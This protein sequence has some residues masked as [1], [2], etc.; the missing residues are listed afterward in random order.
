MGYTYNGHPTACAVAMANLDIIE[1]E[2]LLAKAKD[3]GDYLLRRL[4][5]LTEL[6]VVGE[7]RGV[8]MMLAIELVTDEKSRAPLLPT[9]PVE[10]VARH[11]TGVI[12]RNCGHSVVLS[13]PLSMTRDEAD[14]LA[15]ALTSV[16]RRLRP[17]A[18][19][20]SA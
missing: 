9:P 18:T 1:N 15:D 20:A 8:G 19:W 4:G 16:L 6:S 14:E 11:E 13:P 10:D 12:V 17:D 7:V 3:T 2:G 5:P